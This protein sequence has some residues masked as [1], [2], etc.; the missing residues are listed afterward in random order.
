[1]STE[2]KVNVPILMTCI[3]TACALTCLSQPSQ[4]GV[5]L[6]PGQ[7]EGDTFVADKDAK[8][9]DVLVL[10]GKASV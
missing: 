3:L 10:T 1:M 4:A 8:S 2:R 5:I 7:L 9:P 6:V